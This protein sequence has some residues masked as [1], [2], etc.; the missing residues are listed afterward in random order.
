MAERTPRSARPHLDE[1][2]VF[3]EVALAGSLA[4]AARRAG[5]PK[6]T[7]GRAIA[8]LEEEVRAPL[9]RRTGGG[10]TDA[11]RALAIQA[12][13]HV[14]ALRG[15][16]AA[17]RG[18]GAEVHGTLRVTATSDLAQVVLGPLVAAFVARYPQVNIEVDATIRMVDLA[19]EGF[20]LALRVARR[21]LAP[22]SLVARKLARLDLGLFA[23]PTYLARR[24]TPRRAADLADHDHVL[25][26]GS[27]GRGVIAVDGPHGAERVAVRGQT[28]GNDF[29]FMRE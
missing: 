13:P 18:A 28:S 29:N 22:S 27:G 3:V 12:G 1:L 8:R 20:D 15:A 10:L 17:L 9:V 11:G 2:A 6:S 19:A 7:I 5:V 26:L 16:A 14:Q 21:S 23:S 24:G 4:A 25:L